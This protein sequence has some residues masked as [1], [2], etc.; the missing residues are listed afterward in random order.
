[1][2]DSWSEIDIPVKHNNANYAAVFNSSLPGKLTLRMKGACARCVV[3]NVFKNGTVVD[4]RLL[5]TIA[6]YRKELNSRGGIN[7]GQYFNWNENSKAIL[8]END[9]P[10]QSRLMHDVE[11]NSICN[12]R[13]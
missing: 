4:G 7:F 2:E 3:V 6:N 9:T 10:I 8:N 5:Q 13:G 12:V 1:M 11:L